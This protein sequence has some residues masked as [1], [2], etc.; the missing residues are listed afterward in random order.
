MSVIKKLFEQLPVSA[1][2]TYKSLPQDIL[3]VGA[4]SLQIFTEDAPS[5]GFRLQ[6]SNADE[7]ELA[8]DAKWISAD[9]NGYLPDYGLTF[10]GGSWAVSGAISAAIFSSSVGN[11]F[12]WLRAVYDHISGAGK[13]TIIF[14]AK[15]P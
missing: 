5:G 10:S 7:S 14:V 12:R 1:A 15:S 8:D 11:T 6:F 4:W 9:M 13:M 3:S 2:A